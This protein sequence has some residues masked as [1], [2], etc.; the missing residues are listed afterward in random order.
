MYKG[1]DIDGL[2]IH[3]EHEG[4]TAS[5]ARKQS[6]RVI[7][8]KGDTR[9][10]MR[11]RC[12]AGQKVLASLVMPGWRSPRASASTAASSRSTSRPP[13]STRCR[14]HHTH[15]RTSG[16]RD[17]RRRPLSR[18]PSPPSRTPTL[19]QA[20]IESFADAL[21]EIIK[22]R[23]QQSNF[24]LIVI[25]HDEEFVQRI[26]RSENCSHYFRIDKRVSDGQ[27]HT[28][29]PHSTIDRFDIGRFG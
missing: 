25:T 23:K 5:G 4:E 7:M 8:T 15:D 19:R 10:D 28:A 27:S 22:A 16:G 24:Q 9:L 3:S 26:G 6:Y 14:S 18:S 29:A 17:H 1:R 13:T 12:S 21:N 11:G 20:N 2:E